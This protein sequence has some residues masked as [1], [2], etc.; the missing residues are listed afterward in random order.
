[1]N[2]YDV[3]PTGDQFDSIRMPDVRVQGF[4]ACFASYQPAAGRQVFA[5]DACKAGLGTP[6]A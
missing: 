3:R 4:T 2:L 5:K 1:M 6:E